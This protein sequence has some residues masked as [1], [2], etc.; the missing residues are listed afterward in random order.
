M[1]LKLDENF[2]A[3]IVPQLI[4]EGFDTDTVGAEGLAGSPDETIY[5]TCKSV[6]RTLLTLDLD[7]SNPF[8]FPPRNSEGIIVV[9]P[10]RAVLASIQATL[11]SVITQLKTRSPKGK[12][13]IIEAGRIRE[14][15]P[16]E[17]DGTS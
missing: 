12:L 1:K 3:R 16:N 11:F 14:H 9:R 4:K 8:R 17:G 5:D 7:F 2:D 6:G 13:W 10:P 15:D